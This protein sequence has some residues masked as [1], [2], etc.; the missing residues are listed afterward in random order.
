MNVGLFLF[1]SSSAGSGMNLGSTASPLR[2]LISNS[3]LFG[4]KEGFKNVYSKI[5][6]YLTPL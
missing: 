6:K 5:N 2:S 3:M 4:C 1:A